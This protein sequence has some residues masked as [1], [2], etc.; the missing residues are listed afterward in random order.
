MFRAQVI[1]KVGMSP[2]TEAA[3]CS[4]VEIWEKKSVGVF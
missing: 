4:M 3:A 1:G 2:V